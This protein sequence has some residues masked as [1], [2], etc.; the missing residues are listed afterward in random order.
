MKIGILTFHWG[1]NHGAILQAY[2]LSE[3]L[4]KSYNA[5]VE[6]IDYYPRNLELSIKNALLQKRPSVIYRKLKELKK[7]RVLRPFRQKLN[8]TRRYYTNDEL[9]T[10]KIDYDYLIC[11]SDQ[12]WNPSF[13]LYGEKKITPVYYLNFEAGEA[14]KLAVSAS[15]GC[16]MLSDDCIEIV[17][18]L[19]Y[20]FQ[21]IS[22]RENSGKNILNKIGV[23]D[24]VVVSDPTALLS[25]EVYAEISKEGKACAPHR[26]TKFILRK[27]SK[28]NRKLIRKIS[29][30]V[31]NE[32][33]CDIE[34]LSIPDWLASIK[35]S[36]LVITNSFHCVIMCLKLHTP[37][38]VVQE[39]GKLAGMNDRFTTLLGELGLSDRVIKNETDI[40]VL[41]SIDFERVDDAMERY[42][43]TLKSFIKRNIE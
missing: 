42:A 10:D 32:M 31:A 15:F 43:E 16:E 18:P 35:E 33:P 26:V 24:A 27:Q 7:E 2:A 23:I 39:D 34:K 30:S 11:G 6:I 9:K 1:A 8:L 19:L 20:Q 17:R 12:M 21:G 41:A 28:A 3:Y 29:D 37:F 4:R 25:G 38:I 22:V 13:L 5:D 40:P 14:K 36:R